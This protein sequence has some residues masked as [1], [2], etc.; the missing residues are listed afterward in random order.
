MDS[1]HLLPIRKQCQGIVGQ[2]TPLAGAG[3]TF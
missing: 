3:A 1:G 2:G